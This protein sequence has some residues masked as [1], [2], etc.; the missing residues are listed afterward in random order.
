MPTD[1]ED[2]T[3]FVTVAQGMA[4]F[5]AVHMWWNDED[6]TI[7]GFWEPWDSDKCYHKTREAAQPCAEAW[8]ESEGLRYVA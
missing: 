7:G 3:G 8:A 5:F 2:K 4:G 6:P 1:L